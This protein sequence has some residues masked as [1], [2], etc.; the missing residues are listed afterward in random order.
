M[1]KLLLLVM[2]FVMSFAQA[3]QFH[4]VGIP[5]NERVPDFTRD[6]VVTF[7][8]TFALG[9]IAAQELDDSGA[10]PI[11]GILVGTAIGA[12]IGYAKDRAWDI[13]Y[14]NA[15]PNL[16]PNYNDTKWGA[17]GGFTGA[18]LKVRIPLFRGRGESKAGYGRRYRSRRW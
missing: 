7:A 16:H 4:D 8:G 10:H 11:I 2:V 14:N 9:S 3:Q 1:K 12:G 6:Q 5:L 15:I 13:R 17:I 18:I